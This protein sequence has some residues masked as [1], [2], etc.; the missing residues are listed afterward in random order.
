MLLAGSASGL[1]N[2][3]SAS[4]AGAIIRPLWW[5]L[6]LGPQLMPVAAGLKQ[7]RLPD[8]TGQRW[9]RFSELVAV[10]LWAR[11]N[12]LAGWI[13]CEGYILTTTGIELPE[14]PSRLLLKTGPVAIQEEQFMGADAALEDRGHEFQKLFCNLH[15]IFKS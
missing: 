11:S 10:H 14:T 2:L 1:L 15:P 6:R 9:A 8:T 13:Q 4:T 7:P 3:P 5:K 12:L